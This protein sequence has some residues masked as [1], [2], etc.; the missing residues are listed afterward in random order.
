MSKRTS[1]R[2]FL[3]VATASSVATGFAP[4]IL[5]SKTHTLARKPVAK[6]YAAND[7]IQLACIGFGGMGHGDTRTALQVDGVEFV[8]AADCYK[9][10]LDHAKEV[11]GKNLFTTLDYREIIA[12]PDVDAIIIATP[13]H[14]HAKIT[15]EALNAGKA[16]YCEKPMVQKVEEGAGVIQAEQDTGNLLIVGSQRVSSL[17]YEKAR[18]LYQSGAIGELNMVEAVLNRN[19]ATGAWQYTI[20]PD[21][22]EETCDWQTFV[23][24]APKR[25]FDPKRF[26]RWRNY[27]DYGTGIPGDLFVHL[28]SG[29]HLVLDSNGPERIMSTGGLRY[30]I[31]GRDVPDI[32]LGLYDYPKTETHPAFNMS[33]QVNF[34]DGAGGGTQF[35]FIGNEGVITINSRD[36]TLTRLAP[37]SEPGYT[38]GTFTRE[39]REK[40]LSDYRAQYPEPKRPELRG[41]TEEVFSAPNG[42]N[43]RFDHFT[44]F[45]TAM[46]EDG[47][48]VEDGAY[49]LRAAAPA[50][51]TNVSY[52]TRQIV[53][54]DPNAMQ[55]KKQM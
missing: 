2:E 21:A 47:S 4:N 29:I 36:T 40:A 27:Q 8:A 11:Y 6:K 35:R 48:V 44:N 22:S 46:R 41:L 34:A 54:W 38:I 15:I 1:R 13:D 50:L 3:R 43:D 14:W 28:F 17:I 18:E 52:E 37:R 45:F 39:M 26:F 24:H 33:L 31:D 53:E 20:P 16:V 30:W 19:S 42:Y 9:G 12:R 32:M 5:T 55:L 7:K 49:G 51:L 25:A 23:G 10:R